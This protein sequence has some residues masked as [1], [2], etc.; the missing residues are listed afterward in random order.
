MWDALI[1]IWVNTPKPA[2]LSMK[3]YPGIDTTLWLDFT[4]ACLWRAKEIGKPEFGKQVRHCKE[5]SSGWTIWKE[6]IPRAPTGI[7]T[8]GSDP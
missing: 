5:L 8:A 7:R 6:I 4:R 2:R 1:T 3:P